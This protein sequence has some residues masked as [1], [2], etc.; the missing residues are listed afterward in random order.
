MSKIIL[1]EQ[2]IREQIAKCKRA[3]DKI[4]MQLDKIEAERKEL[5]DAIDTVNEELEVLVIELK[6]EQDRDKILGLEDD[7]DNY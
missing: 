4:Y 6:F 2:R 7:Y 5:F 1:N 3:K